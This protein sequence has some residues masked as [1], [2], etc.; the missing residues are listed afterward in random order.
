MKHLDDGTLQAFLDHEL[1]S[2]ERASAAEHILACDDCR[3]V[4][5]DLARANA[6]F[7]EAMAA[8]D[9]A[10]PERAAPTARDGG[11]LGLGAGSL[12][13]A[14][15]LVLL[16]AAAAS[17]AV[18]GSP[19]RQWITGA[20]E[21][22]PV[23]EPTVREIE[24]VEVDAPVDAPPAGVSFAPGDDVEIVITGMEDATIRLVETDGRDVTVA[25]R[26][27][28]TDPT[29]STGSGVIEIRG[30]VGGVLTIQLPRSLRSARLLVDG[31]LYAEKEAGALHLRVPADSDG[32]HVWR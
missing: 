4:R 29:F 32:A 11:G 16:V 23:V 3:E 9:V 18:P 1:T 20:V 5:D 22:A 10:A 17:A 12:V 30:G 27:A 14:A 2:G 21:P 28:T 13:K 8:V 15:G 31:E 25:A 24:P 6:V 7:A 26:G 19:V